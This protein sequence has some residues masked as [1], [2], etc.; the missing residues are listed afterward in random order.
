[1]GVL[2]SMIRSGVSL[3]RSVEFTLQW[4]KILRTGPVYPVSLGDP[5]SV[6]EGS[7]GEFRRAN[8]DLHCTL[9]DFVHMVVVHRRDEAIRGW[10][11]LLREDPLAHSFKWLRPDMVPTAPFLQCKPHLTPVGSGTP[12]DPA[13]I[14][15]WLPYFCRSGQREASLE[16]FAEEVDGWL[17]MLRLIFLS[18]LAGEMLA[19]VVRRKCW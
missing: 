15:A 17:P 6:R 18:E 4:E 13:S 8:G 5:Q 14:E 2:D 9:T 3:A 7:I 16:E 19:G 1:M 11:N 12:A 10:R